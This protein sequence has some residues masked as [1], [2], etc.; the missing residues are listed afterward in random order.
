MP[1]SPPNQFLSVKIGSDTSYYSELDQVFS[2]DKLSWKI[3]TSEK[4]LSKTEDVKVVQPVVVKPI[5]P[6]FDLY[7]ETPYDIPLIS[8]YEI[9]KLSKIIKKSVDNLLE[10]SQGFYYLKQIDD[11]VFI[12]LQN[13]AYESDTY[14]RHGLQIAEISQDGAILYHTAGYAGVDG[15]ISAPEVLDNDSW[16]YDKTTEPYRPIKHIAYDEKGKVKF[17]EYWN[18][19]TEDSVKYE[20]KDN[21]NK[22]VSVLKEIVEDGTNYRKEHIFYD[23]EGNTI[24]S[25]SINFEGANI[26]RFNYYNAKKPESSVIVMSDYVDGMKSFEKIYDKDY[27]LVNIVEASYENGERKEVKLFD[28]EK[29]ELGKISS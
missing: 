25:I 26:T 28:S 22:T 14:P 12:I 4:E 16:V 18:Y 27:S 21:H 5:L 29:N 8:I 23:N 17:T 10:Q 7:S 20:M 24:V 2:Q 6:K 1:S 19:S 3:I 9:S 15:E 13:P 11:K